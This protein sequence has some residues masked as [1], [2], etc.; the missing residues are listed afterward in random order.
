MADAIKSAVFSRRAHPNRQAE[1]LGS[2]D[3]TSR[4]SKLAESW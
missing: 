2:I 1:K 4:S 3:S